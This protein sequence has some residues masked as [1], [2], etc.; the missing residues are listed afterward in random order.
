MKNQEYEAW[1][2]KQIEARFQIQRAQ[3]RRVRN[4]FSNFQRSKRVIARELK[5]EKQRCREKRLKIIDLIK[6]YMEL[7]QFKEL[8]RDLLYVQ[9]R[10]WAETFYDDVL[11]VEAQGKLGQVQS[12]QGRVWRNEPIKF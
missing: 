2:E 10:S 3:F 8:A 7:P 12:F 5:A 4:T 11:E 1:V 6:P 9:E